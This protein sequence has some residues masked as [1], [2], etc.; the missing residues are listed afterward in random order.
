[1]NKIKEA[2]STIK[3]DESLKNKTYLSLT[4]TH[5]K[6]VHLFRPIIILNTA[7]VLMLVSIINFNKLENNI[8]SINDGRNIDNDLNVNVS[9]ES[10]FSIYSF[11]YKENNYF[12][13]DIIINSSDLNTNLGNLDKLVVMDSS[14]GNSQDY[15]LYTV[16]NNDNVLVIKYGDILYPFEKE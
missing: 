14:L 2:F 5:P 11:T 4:S 3:V 13:S 7:L 9:S 1:M 15:Q 16:K 12:P 6:K 10:A 8:Y